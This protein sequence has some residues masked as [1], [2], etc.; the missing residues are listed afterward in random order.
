MDI[1]DNPE[2]I[3]V[4]KEEG[5]DLINKMRENLSLLNRD[6]RYVN[7]DI[8]IKELFRCAHTLRG[9][10]GMVAGFHGLGE[11][12]RVLVEIFR[13]AKDGRLKIGPGIIPLL[14]EGVE[15]CQKLLDREEVGDYEGLVGR[16]H[17]ILD[18]KILK[19]RTQ[20]PGRY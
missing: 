2:L 16:L 1:A 4:F 8:R 7:E 5:Q 17:D 10:S 19:R 12:A 11:M 20:W 9:S 13:S 15:A 14:S 3:K 6:I 18:F